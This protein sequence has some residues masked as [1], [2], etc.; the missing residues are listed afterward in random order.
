[1]P[2]NVRVLS[3]SECLLAPAPTERNFRNEGVIHLCWGGIL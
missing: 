1:M 2:K 3:E